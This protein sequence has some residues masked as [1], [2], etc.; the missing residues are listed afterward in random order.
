[1]VSV[2]NR[3]PSDLTTIARRNGGKYPAE[4]VFRTIDGRNAVLGH[5]GQGMPVWG[6]A[7][8]RAQGGATP[9]VIRARVEALVNYLET[10]QQKP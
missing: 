1:M 7:F 8:L 4:M 10:I 3:R 6:D 9:E 2:L 5:G